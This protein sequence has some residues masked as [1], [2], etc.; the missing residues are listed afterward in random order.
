[1]KW[2]NK[3]ALYVFIIYLGVSFLYIYFSDSLLYAWFEDPETITKFQNYKG[4]GFVLITAFLLLVTINKQYNKKNELIVTL[5]RKKREYQEMYRKHKEVNNTLENKLKEI[6]TINRELD[7]AKKRAEENNQLKSAF[8]ANMSHEIRTPMNGIMGFAQLLNEREINAKE[9][10]EFLN[11][12]YS[13]SQHLL[14]II[15]DIIDIS[16]IE[17]NQLD[18]HYK[19]FDLNELLFKIYEEQK[20]TLAEIGKSQIELSVEYISNQ[21]G[22]YI[23][24]DRNRLRQVMDNLLSNAT[25]FTNEGEIKFGCRMSGEREIEFY[26]KDTG[27]GIPEDKQK[28]IFERFRRGDESISPRYEGTG[29]GLTISKKLV[30]LMGGEMWLNSEPKKGSC[31]Y[32]TLPYY[33]DK[34]DQQEVKASASEQNINWQGKTILLVED[35]PASKEYIKETL[36]STGVNLVI[37]AKGNQAIKQIK[38]N[39]EINLALIDI[40]LPD[41][42]G[43]DVSRE[44]R[45]FNQQIPVIV[46]TAHAMSEDR[47]KSIEAGA[48]DYLSK[49]IDVN[50]LLSLI[51]KYL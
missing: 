15:N 18:V 32:F 44:I 2:I 43:L 33:K 39:P 45:K 27:I 42:S 10:K 5:N 50:D 8:L 3:S 14:Q 9:R 40:R 22:F 46:Q 37:S 48:D 13:R 28:E 24:S 4:W 31:F 34:A 21:N 36:I 17:A 30:E 49:P 51:G 38:E 16:K 19:S 6:R 23:K 11:I 7:K 41:I 47:K 12:I 1:M 25:K 35:D 29:L 20:E 26:V